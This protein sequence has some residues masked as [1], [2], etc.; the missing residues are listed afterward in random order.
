LKGDE[1]Q[2]SSEGSDEDMEEDEDD[3][4]AANKRMEDAEDFDFGD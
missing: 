4:V 2:D 1:D 3:A